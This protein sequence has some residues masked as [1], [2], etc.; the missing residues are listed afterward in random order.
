M[1]FMV[2]LTTLGTGC[3]LLLSNP[4]R[5][6]I[7][8]SITHL[9]NTPPNPL[10]RYTSE[11]NANSPKITILKYHIPEAH[12]CISHL[13]STHQRDSCQTQVYPYDF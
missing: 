4:C 13:F 1:V 6:S 11:R 9:A 5:V 2:L 12:S 8:P 10:A 7:D 3:L